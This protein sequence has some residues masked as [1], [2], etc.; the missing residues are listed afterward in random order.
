MTMIALAQER[1]QTVV[2]VTQASVRFLNNYLFKV[3]DM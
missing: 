3:Y 2:N 1:T